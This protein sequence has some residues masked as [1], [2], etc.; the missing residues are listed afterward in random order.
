MF[1]MKINSNIK[2]NNFKNPLNFK[3]NSHREKYIKRSAEA[4]KEKNKQIAISSLA[5]LGLTGAIIFAIKN[6][7]NNQPQPEVITSIE[8]AQ[9]PTIPTEIAEETLNYV[10][11][12][13]LEDVNETQEILDD[14]IN[15][16]EIDTQQPVSEEDIPIQIDE[17]KLENWIDSKTQDGFCDKVKKISQDINCEYYDLLA[18]M[19]SESSFN[20]KAKC[21]GHVGLLQFGYQQLK[22]IGY[23]YYS[24]EQMSAF[25]QLDVA[26]KYLKYV[27]SFH[28]QEDEYL[29]AGDLYAIIFLPG[30]SNLDILC[31]KGTDY[32]NNNSS[33]DKDYNGDISKLDLAVHLAHKFNQICELADAI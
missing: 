17:A 6:T 4:K 26:N 21:Q 32:Y 9:T 22:E 5:A 3:A 12:E 29:S 8:N 2:Y 1:T 27:K 18:L 20:P 23:N 10:V 15:E 30:L 19:F 11:A 33:L 16:T 28:F 14:N 13:T 7:N 25:E 24:V 31:Y